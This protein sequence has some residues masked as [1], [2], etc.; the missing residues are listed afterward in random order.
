M[1][2]GSDPLLTLLS[3]VKQE[4]VVRAFLSLYQTSRLDP[5]G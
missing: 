2:H 3:V 4:L 1:R 5:D